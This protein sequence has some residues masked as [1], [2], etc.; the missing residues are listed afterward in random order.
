M[1]DIVSLKVNFQLVK[2]NNRNILLSVVIDGKVFIR[3][4][5]VEIIHRELMKIKS[6]LFID[7]YKR[8]PSSFCTKLV[9]P[10]Y[11]VLSNSLWLSSG[12]SKFLQNSNYQSNKYF[13]LSF[14]LI[15][16]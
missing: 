14:W 7:F 2:Q 5:N 3:L 12:A 4:Q 10:K 1:L 16:D 9:S 6:D 11:K 13:I 8:I 15:H